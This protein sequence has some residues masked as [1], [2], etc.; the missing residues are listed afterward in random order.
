MIRVT[1]PLRY[2]GGKYRVI[3]KIL[4]FVPAGFSEYREPF[5]GGG[6][7]FIFLKQLFPGAK[8]RIGD[9]NRP[10]YSFWV[11]LQNNSHEFIE[12]II[13]IKNSC[14][15]GASLYNSLK[16]PVESSDIFHQAVRFFILN[17]ITY[18]GTMDSGGYSVE[19]FE[20][21][22]TTSNISK[23]E[24][25]SNLLQE[26]EIVNESYEK[27][28]FEPGDNVFIYLDPPYWA[29]R[30]SKL[31]GKHGDLHSFFDHKQFSED[32]KQC[33]HS[34][35]M[36]CDDSDIMR[37]LFG[38]GRISSWEMSY[39]MTNVNSKKSDIGRELFVS[40]YSVPLDSSLVS[41]SLTFEK[42]RTF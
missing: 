20:K 15:D 35:L 17:R 34:W 31:Y 41:S 39:G 24:P 3:K 4:P 11:T 36:T 19:A 13:R 8:Y 9:L 32:V 25:L 14:K 2:P 28:L 22:F 37:E 21:R 42:A 23:L 38:F 40:N 5:L 18:S 16:K 12:E 29:S 1:S 30:K 6:S 7:L 27:F 10:L 33:R 26:V